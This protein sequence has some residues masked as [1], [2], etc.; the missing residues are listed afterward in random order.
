MPPCLRES[1]TRVQV[2]EGEQNKHNLGGR[3]AVAHESLVFVEIKYILFDKSGKNSLLLALV[4][5]ISLPESITKSL[6]LEWFEF[7]II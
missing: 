3:D 5:Y 4:M 7:G 2:L 6:V 1:T